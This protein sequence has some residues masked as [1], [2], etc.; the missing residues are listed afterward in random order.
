L[1]L[2]SPVDDPVLLM[3]EELGLPI[4]HVVDDEHVGD[5]EMMTIESF[6]HR[7]EEGQ[8][9]AKCNTTTDVL[10]YPVDV[11]LYDGRYVLLFATT[12]AQSS[13]PVVNNESMDRYR[14]LTL[15]ISSVFSKTVQQTHRTTP[16][17]DPELQGPQTVDWQTYDDDGGGLSPTPQRAVEILR[18][19]G[20]AIASVQRLYSRTNCTPTVATP[21]VVDGIA[22]ASSGSSSTDDSFY[23]CFVDEQQQTRSR[24][25]CLGLPGDT[26][27]ASAATTRTAMLSTMM[28]M[29]AL[30]LTIVASSVFLS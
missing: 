25:I 18:R 29:A 2:A 26:S 6:F 30:T 4:L 16:L 21:P 13:L 5:E 3:L 14:P 23:K 1:Y 9:L 28:M 11:W 27:S 24:Q 12:T 20:P 7:C 15:M 8:D 10:R 22:A 17:N 19:V